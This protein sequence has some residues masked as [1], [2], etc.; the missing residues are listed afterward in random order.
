MKKLTALLLTLSVTITMLLA[1][2][3][4]S[5][6]GSTAD[7]GSANASADTGSAATAVSEEDE[8]NYNTGDASLDNVRNQ[9]DIGENELLVL[10]F[11][12]SFNDS[13]RLTIGAIE[14]DLEAAFPDYSV[15]RGFTANIVINH[16]QRRDGILIDDVDA[17]LNR[18]V[19]NGVK[20]LVVQPTHLMDGLEYQELV[21]KVAEYSDAFDKVAFGKP[22]LTSDDD[23]ARV[24][25][26]ITEWTKE[27][28]DG[29]TAICF[30]GHGTEAESNQV[31]QKMQD[32]LTAD[33]YK[34]YFV[35]TVEATPSL[36]DVLAA[37]KAGNYKRVVLQPLMVVAGDHANN[38]MAGDEEGSWKTIFEDAG[39][40]VECVLHGLGE[41]E[42]IRQIYIDHAQEAIDSL[43]Q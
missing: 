13:R 23:F 27:Y 43:N 7:T 5:S 32:K 20:N 34:N 25:K 37:V 40:E 30:M 21:D 16:V 31:Y 28:D 33:G 6:S 11:G 39:Y 3:S 17:A 29:E 41:N 18:A 22:L 15:R 2:C 24:E 8:E 12:T 26:A 35:G 4:S 19:D 14:N 10:S 42:E 38:D 1:G 36:D 9:D